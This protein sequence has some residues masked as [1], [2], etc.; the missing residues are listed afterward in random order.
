MRVT[1]SMYKTRLYRT[2]INMKSRCYTPSSSH[3]KY[4]GGKG[5]KV[6]DEWKNN[7][8]NFYNWSIKNGYKENLTI[9]RIDNNKNYE[10]NNCRWATYQMQNDNLPNAIK[11]KYQN[12]IYTL[13]EICQMTGLTKKCIRTRYERGWSP[14]RIIETP[15]TKKLER[16]KNGKFT[17][18]KLPN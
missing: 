1:H 7:F 13:T 17:I 15:K 2:W 18:T 11:I 16:D 14:E 5:I 12:K 3:F 9:D 10:P 4:Y 8:L 6:C